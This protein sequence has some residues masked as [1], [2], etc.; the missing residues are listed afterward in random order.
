MRPSGVV[1][2]A[3]VAVLLSACTTTT[4]V[5]GQCRGAVVY[6]PYKGKV[7]TPVPPTALPKDPGPGFLYTRVVYGHADDTAYAYIVHVSDV[8]TQLLAIVGPLR[9]TTDH[10]DY[11]GFFE[12]LC[13]T[14]GRHGPGL[15]SCCPEQKRGEAEPA[16]GAT[17][18][19]KK[20]ALTPII[21]NP[22]P[23][24]GDG[25]AMLLRT[26]D[27]TVNPS[28]PTLAGDAV[29]A[30]GSAYSAMNGG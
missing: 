12:A 6:P 25:S 9:N 10:N 7:P 28:D 8:G 23:P 22:P 5:C 15:G 29:G 3:V 24:P 11:P 21:P 2:A 13:R 14:Y 27:G 20:L 18:A 4:A 1:T 17:G 19:A 26:Q 30:A 16:G